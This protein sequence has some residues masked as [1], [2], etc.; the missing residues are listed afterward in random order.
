M[1]FCQE[2]SNSRL[3]KAADIGAN[4]SGS[5]HYS[6]TFSLALDLSIACDPLDLFVGGLYIPGGTEPR[7]PLAI[8]LSFQLHY[9]GR[10]IPIPWTPSH[11]S[12]K[13]S[14]LDDDHGDN[15]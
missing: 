13:Q 6:K 2:I 8:S 11:L 5:N 3:E 10:I 14:V 7:W 1:L 4:W 12:A 9:P 15:L